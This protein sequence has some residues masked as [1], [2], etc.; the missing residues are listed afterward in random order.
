LKVCLTWTRFDEGTRINEV[1]SSST[2]SASTTYLCV[3]ED[4]TLNNFNVAVSVYQDETF[5]NVFN[6]W[7]DLRIFE[8]DF[9]DIGL[10][11]SLI[12]FG[13]LITFGFIYAGTFGGGLGFILCLFILKVFNLIRINDYIFYT[14]ISL[15]VLITGLIVM[16]RKWKTFIKHYLLD[17]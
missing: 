8:I 15:G 13:S 17:Y 5:V 3:V 9:G 6:E 10:F 7:I 2:V 4:I 12:L 14:L 11:L 1:C 16:N